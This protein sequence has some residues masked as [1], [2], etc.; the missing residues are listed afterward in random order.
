MEGIF[1]VMVVNRDYVHPKVEEPWESENNAQKWWDHLWIT[2]LEKKHFR[3]QGMNNPIT[4]SS[5][6]G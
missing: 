3:V 5:A 6:P 1:N 4:A 2:I